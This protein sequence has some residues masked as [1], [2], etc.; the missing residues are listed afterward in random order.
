MDA[1]WEKY[2]C[3]PEIG[4]LI[5]DYRQSVRQLEYI[6]RDLRTRHNID[7]LITASDAQAEL[8]RHIKGLVWLEEAALARDRRDT[9]WL[10]LSSAAAVLGFL[11][12]LVAFGIF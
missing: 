3:H 10:Y 2:D 7:T 4:P 1:Q 6:K 12:L 8:V 5:E 9:A 11:N